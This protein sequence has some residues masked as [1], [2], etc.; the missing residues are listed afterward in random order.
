[1]EV[2]A[3]E[4]LARGDE[5]FQKNHIFNIKHI[6][7]KTEKNSPFMFSRVSIQKTNNG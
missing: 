7:I 4:S 2:Y 3:D 1:M 6:Q 5:T